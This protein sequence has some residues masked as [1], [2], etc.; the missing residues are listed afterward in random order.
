MHQ[1][2]I[3][4]VGRGDLP[5]G[6]AF[7]KLMTFPRPKDRL[8]YAL[9]SLPAVHEAR[10]LAAVAAAGIPCPAVLAAFAARRG[11]L[12]AT[13][14][15]VLR[16]LPVAASAGPSAPDELLRERA[17]LGARLL[18]AGIVH[19][20][21][22]SANFVRLADGRLAVLDLQSASICHR[23]ARFHAVGIAARL[24]RDVDDPDSPGA[25]AAMLD[26][27]L[28]ADAAA[29]DLARQRAAVDARAFVTGRIRRCLGESTEFTRRLRATG[30]EHRRRGDL[31]AGRWIRGGREL[32]R[33]WIGQR[34]LEVFENRSPRLHA[35]LASWWWLH[36]H[37]AVYVPG[38][39]DEPSLRSELQVLAE[40]Y[41][42]W[43]PRRRWV[44]QV[45]EESGT[46]AKVSCANRVMRAV[47]RKVG[48]DADS[49]P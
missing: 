48:D 8:R 46:R 7:V 24:L 47:M 5:S 3:R 25:A 26:S 28:L 49:E 18:A 21:L 13:S 10:M 42:R 9:R 20:D 4:A 2:L 12:P 44:G 17:V 27:G 37:S 39:I 1:R 11:F 36:G 34:A 33:C 45:E 41:V 14:M 23:P 6:P 43:L 31:P 22:N 16:A 40:G 19:R 29:V 15:L 38:D 35:F 30:I 32:R